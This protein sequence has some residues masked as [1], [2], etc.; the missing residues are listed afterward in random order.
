[1]VVTP[2]MV[3]SAIIARA[4]G[5]A[6]RYL[7]SSDACTLMHPIGGILRTSAG[8]ICPNATTTI[9]SGAISPSLL[10][11]PGS[12]I[13]EGVRTGRP[14]RTPSDLTGD[15]SACENCRRRGLS[16]RVT[17]AR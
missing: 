9:T 1:M 5:A 17:T 11:N 6:P 7:G 8:K 2:V 14:T 16:G 10:D 15:G 3:S 4:I 13:D 12:L